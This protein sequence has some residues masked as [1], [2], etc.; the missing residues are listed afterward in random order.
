MLETV[1][2]MGVRDLP[3]NELRDLLRDGDVQ[4]E[5]IPRK[6]RWHYQ[7]L[8]RECYCATVKA[9]TGQWTYRGFDWHTFE[10]GFARSRLGLKALNAYFA[11]TAGDFLVIPAHDT[12]P[13]LRC[14][15]DALPDLSPLAP[16]FYVFPPDLEWTM[17][18]SHEG[19][20]FSR[21]EW[22]VP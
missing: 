16:E 11:C 10:F 1:C 13:A 2:D 22:L 18:F 7:Q 3:G 9:R 20:I 21:K 19:P 6:E 5:E 8:W 15:G 14:H 17:V 4:F 12:V